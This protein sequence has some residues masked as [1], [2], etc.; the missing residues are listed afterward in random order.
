MNSLSANKLKTYIKE[1]KRKLSNE[2]KRKNP[3][4]D[5]IAIYEIIIADYQAALIN[6]ELSDDVQ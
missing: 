4:E 1:L 5:M 6:V 2:K 3:N